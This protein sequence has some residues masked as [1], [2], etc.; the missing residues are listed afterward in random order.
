[1]QFHMQSIQKLEHGW[2]V[3]LEKQLKLQSISSR[4]IM[5]W[6]Q[7]IG[8]L[9]EMNTKRLV[10]A[11]NLNLSFTWFL[12]GVHLFLAP[13]LLAVVQAHR[14]RPLCIRLSNLLRQ[15]WRVFR[16]PH[17]FWIAM[18][19]YSNC[20]FSIK[21]S[22]FPYYRF[23]CQS[24][25]VFK[26]WTFFKTRGTKGFMFH[27]WTLLPENLWTWSQVGCYL[28]KVGRKYWN[29]LRWPIL[30]VTQITMVKNNMFWPKGYKVIGSIGF[31]VLSF[32]LCVK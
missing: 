25:Y 8:T 19:W 12:L 24:C 14:D 2:P 6:V 32:K 29:W 23:L 10:P 11:F 1:M 7:W 4:F 17:I 30:I 21:I 3:D 26:F 5:W 9:K 31:I 15:L 13:W 27:L 16:L 22:D 20:Q 28:A 18:V